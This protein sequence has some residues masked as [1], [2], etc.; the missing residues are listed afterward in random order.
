MQNVELSCEITIDSLKAT[1]DNGAED[2]VCSEE[3]NVLRPRCLLYTIRT[4]NDK[5]RELQCTRAMPP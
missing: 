3:D 5:E 1:A 2:I 4:P